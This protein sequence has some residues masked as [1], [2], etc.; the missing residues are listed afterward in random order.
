MLIRLLPC[1]QLNSLKRELMDAQEVVSSRGFEV[2][3]M[4][5]R[6]EELA[7]RLAEKNSSLDAHKEV[8]VLAVVR[9]WSCC[10]IGWFEGGSAQQSSNCCLVVNRACCVVWQC[11][12]NLVLCRNQ[13]SAAIGCCCCV[14]RR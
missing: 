4:Q 11:H 8:R 2:Q 6:L 7:H 3:Q 10:A 1:L 9:C 13:A 5:R 12:Y 14:C